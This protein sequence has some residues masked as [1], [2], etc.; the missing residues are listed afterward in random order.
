M[1]KKE[2][3]EAIKQLKE[4]SPK[5]QFTQ[6]I[7]LVVNLQQ[8][9]LKKNEK[10]DFYV[11]LPHPRSKKVKLGAFVDAQLAQQAK[12]F[13]DVIITKEEFPKWINNKKEQKK[14]ASEH[15]YFVAQV[16][17]MANMAGIFGKILGARGKMP[18]PKAGCVV[19]GN[20]PSLEPLVNRL[21]NTVRL[22]TKNEA[23]LKAAIGD[24]KMKD[25]DVAEN[26]LSVYNNLL[27]KL[28]QGTNNIRYLAL[29]LTM[30]PLLKIQSEA[31]K[32]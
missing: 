8:Y 32:K 2:I 5:K 9:D 20:I 1:E 29:K 31:K 22:Q 17:L 15:D 16:E 18:N 25:E 30:G 24:E 12:K 13:F 3:L 21:Q 7:D 4:K 28:P 11:T 6:S 27:Q 26:I 14:L 23:S 19:P 10:L